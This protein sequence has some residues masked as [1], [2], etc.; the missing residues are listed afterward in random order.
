MDTQHMDELFL[1]PSSPVAMPR[2]YWLDQP[3]LSSQL[4]L[5]EPS[6]VEWHRVQ[7]FMNTPDSGF[8]MDILN[9]M[10]KDSCIIIP[11]K[12]Y[13]LLSGEFR[14]DDHKKYLGSDKEVWDGTKVLEEAKFVHFSDWP[15]PKPWLKAG[16]SIMDKHQPK[17]REGKNGGAE[18]CTDREIWRGLYRDFSERRQKVC[19]RSYDKRHEARSESSLSSPP[20]YEMVL[21]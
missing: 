8:D 3:F 5:V 1:L 14:G 6:D 15:V 7:E 12:N 2:A 11:H 21:P 16:D 18:D 20:K 9:T 13:N 10:Y 19:G 17:C 4:V